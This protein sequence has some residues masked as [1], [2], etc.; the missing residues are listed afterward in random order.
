[1][2][3]IITGDIIN[4]DIYKVSDWMVGLKAYLSTLGNTPKDWDIY[5]GDEFQVKVDPS[6]ALKVAIEIK[7][8][9]KQFKGLDVRMAIGIG[10][11]SYS[12]EGISESNGTAYQFSGRTFETLK[13][14]KLNLAITTSNTNKNTTLNLIFKLA[15][16]FMDNWSIVSAEIVALSLQNPE[17][18]QQEMAN[19]LQIKQSAVSQRLKRAKADL[20]FEVLNFYDNAINEQNL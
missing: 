2:I 3:A 12:G 17:S 14:Q 11:E 6:I 20:V 5:R 1:M 16:E 7:S 8:L 19:V 15:L 18:S 9:I 13:E 4:S 10:E